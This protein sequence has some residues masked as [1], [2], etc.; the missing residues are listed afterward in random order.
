MYFSV[1][2]VISVLVDWC[3][4]ILVRRKDFS[5]PFFMK[6]EPWLLVYWGNE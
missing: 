6:M 3:I 4:D 2:V 1:K 5:P